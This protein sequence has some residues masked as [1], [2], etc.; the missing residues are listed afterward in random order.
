MISG[1]CT[2]LAFLTRLTIPCAGHGSLSHA[3]PWFAPVGLIL[4]LACVLPASIAAFCL[5]GNPLS[6]LLTG[7]VW[8]ACLVWCTRAMHLDAL[9]DLADALGSQTT[10]E[11]FQAILKDPHVGAFAVVSLFALCLA[12]WLCASAHALAIFSPAHALPLILAPAWGRGACL[13]LA[14]RGPA[15]ATST[16]GRMVCQPGTESLARWQYLWGVGCILLLWLAGCPLTRTALLLA[17][18][19]ALHAYLLRAAQ[20]AGGLSGDILGA[21]IELSQTLF[22]LVTL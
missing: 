9:A 5:E 13:V 19:M 4:G 1:A 16:L 11:R 18:Q 14:S 10:G 2:A 22:L 12:Q 6:P 7:F 3:L 17:T 8:F 21:D 20:R 15:S